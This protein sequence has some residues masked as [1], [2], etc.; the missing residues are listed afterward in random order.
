[1]RR[2]SS[3]DRRRFCVDY[4]E[5]PGCCRCPRGT[6]QGE[7]PGEGEAVGRGKVLRGRAPEDEASYCV[8]LRRVQLR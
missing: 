6:A 2:L 3:S 5:G 4:L 1:M 7:S 8:G